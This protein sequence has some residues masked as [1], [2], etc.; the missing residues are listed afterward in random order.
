MRLVDVH[1][2]LGV[3]TAD[4]TSKMSRLTLSQGLLH[5]FAP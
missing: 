1:L 5:A 2:V 4:G 3:E